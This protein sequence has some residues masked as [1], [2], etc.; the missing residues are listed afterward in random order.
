MTTDNTSIE[1]RPLANALAHLERIGA[2]G[3]G[4]TADHE[5]ALDEVKQ[6][7][8]ALLSLQAERDALRADI[9]KYRAR[10]EVDRYGTV[11]PGTPE[12]MMDTVHVDYVSADE[13]IGSCDGIEC[14]DETIKLQDERI[15]ALQ[16]QVEGLREKLEGV[17]AACDEAYRI[18]TS[19]REEHAAGHFWQ[20]GMIARAA[21]S[22]T[23]GEG[24]A[25]QWCTMPGGKHDD[26]CP[27]TSRD[28]R[29]TLHPQFVAGVRAAR[30]V[31]IDA[32]SSGE[33]SDAW[34]ITRDYA[35]VQMMIDVGA[36]IGEG[37]IRF[38]DEAM[39]KRNKAPRADTPALSP[40]GSGEEVRALLTEMMQATGRLAFYGANVDATDGT[41]YNVKPIWI[42]M[43]TAFAR[44]KG[45][46][47][48]TPKGWGWPETTLPSPIAS[49]DEWQPMETA[50]RTRPIV[51]ETAAGRVFKAKWVVIGD[52]ATGWGTVEEDDPRP[53]CWTDGF[54][55]ASNADEEPS[56]PPVRWHE[57]HA[58][59]VKT[60][61]AIASG[62][63]GGAA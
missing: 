11:G 19:R 26:G 43:L 41:G 38:V 21:L 3:E 24:G 53:T 33:N 29:E 35:F 10:L 62:D 60:S 14:R 52:D 1:E 6:A 45:V 36:V 20:I 17:G 56:D 2:S 46:A 44:E 28:G 37:H 61:Q 51:V 7:A 32:H 22:L 42:A 48:D 59:S 31:L 25:C 15:A 8:R 55:W 58:S 4:G 57:L 16:E 9:D 40:I 39:A 12:G 5:I 50:P 23:P 30:D 63:E 18:A 34:T 47:L 13:D 49:G 54:C 27:Y